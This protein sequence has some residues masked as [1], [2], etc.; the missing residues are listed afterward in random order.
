[1]SS[2]NSRFKKRAGKPRARGLDLLK[3]MVP[4]GR[5]SALVGVL[6]HAMKSRHTAKISKKRRK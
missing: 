6:E 4:V 2:S 3:I 1:M 5:P